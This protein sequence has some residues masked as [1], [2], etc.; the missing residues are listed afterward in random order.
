MINFFI[1]TLSLILSFINLFIVRF[2]VE[3]AQTISNIRSLLVIGLMV[4]PLTIFGLDT[5]IGKIKP[6][7]ITQLSIM[8]VV[9]S[10]LLTI[11]ANLVDHYIINV[12]L[13][14]L[15]MG[16]VQFIVADFLNRGYHTAFK[17]FSQIVPKIFLLSSLVSSSVIF[18][19]IGGFITINSIIMIIFC[20]IIVNKNFL[21]LTNFYY[22]KKSDI[23]GLANLSLKGLSALFVT[24]LFVRLPYLLSLSGPPDISNEFDIATAFTSSWILPLAIA[25]RI[26]E[27]QGGYHYQTYKNTIRPLKVGILLQIATLILT[28]IMLIYVLTSLSFI[29]ETFTGVMT[30]MIFTGWPALLIVILPNITRMYYLSERH[31]F[32][33]SFGT[34]T[35]LVFICAVL[36][37][38][39]I[40]K[41]Q[42][43][44]SGI[45]LLIIFFMYL[46]LQ[47]EKEVPGNKS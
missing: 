8:F 10:I 41:N 5:I 21:P 32:S 31:R 16:T 24:D 7:L 11:F 30:A 28:S 42:L 22:I 45:L 39:S 25:T 29:T 2:L 33:S 17:V 6:I 15:T 3:D 35:S 18:D 23:L 43:I 46:I 44:L 12:A 19:N 36:G 20:L 13:L 9:V 38:T 4:S 1:L 26:H 34:I 40:L 14:A 37:V 47:G 27:V